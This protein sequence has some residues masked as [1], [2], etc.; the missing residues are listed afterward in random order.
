MPRIDLA[1][2]ERPTFPE[3]GVLLAPVNSNVTDQ[4]QVTNNGDVL[5]E[6]VAS[7]SVSI[8]FTATTKGDAWTRDVAM[9]SGQRRVFGPFEPAFFNIHA[10]AA[11][12]TKVYIDQVGGVAGNLTYAAF[13]Q[14]LFLR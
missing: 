11:D 6:V 14:P 13:R 4:H 2:V 1:I 10:A 7:A 3:A 9:T 12:P 8:R 5:V